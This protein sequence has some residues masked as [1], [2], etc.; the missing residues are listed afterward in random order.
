MFLSLFLL[1]FFLAIF[2][3]GHRSLAFLEIPAARGKKEEISEGGRFVVKAMFIMISIIMG[4][5]ITTGSGIG[6]TLVVLK[7]SMLRMREVHAIILNVIGSIRMMLRMGWFT[8]TRMSGLLLA[9]KWR[10]FGHLV[11]YMRILVILGF[12]ILVIL[13]FKERVM[14]GFR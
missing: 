13:R 6:M 10:A 2:L 8:R 12:R 4:L 3:G 5:L 1:I 7:G 11:S 9:M 14:L